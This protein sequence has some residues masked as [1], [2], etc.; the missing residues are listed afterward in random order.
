MAKLYGRILA[1]LGF[2]SDGSVELKTPSDLTGSAVGETAEKTS[3]VIENTRGKVLVIDEA[4]ALNEGMRG[5]G[6]EAL[7]TLVSKV[8]NKPGDDIAVIMCGYE[9]QMRKLLLDQNPGLQR[10]F[11]LDSAFRFD[12][13]TD[14]ELRRI[15]VALAE[16]DGLVLP[17]DQANAAV[18]LLA[19]QRSR[20]NFGEDIHAP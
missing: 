12:D 13:F 18:M 10:R 2:L 20:P 19:K 16:K 7:D 14:D 6:R 11:G 17:R 4:Y 1:A 3:A 9:A 8:H 5:Y 15:L